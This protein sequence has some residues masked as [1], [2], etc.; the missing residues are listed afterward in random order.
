MRPGPTSGK[1]PTTRVAASVQQ[2][3]VSAALLCKLAASPRQNR[4]VQALA[5][6][7]QLEQTLFL[8]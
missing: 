8:V 1:L 5:E 6:L 4:L 7:G 2:G 3:T